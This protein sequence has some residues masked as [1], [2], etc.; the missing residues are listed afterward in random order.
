LVAAVAAQ[1]TRSP[2]RSARS[3]AAV[4]VSSPALGGVVHDLRRTVIRGQLG[5]P[6]VRVRLALSSS[7]LR[8]RLQ[9]QPPHL[10]RPAPPASRSARCSR[11]PCRASRTTSSVPN[12]SGVPVVPEQLE[13]VHVRLQFHQRFGQC[14]K[15]P[16]PQLGASRSRAGHELRAGRRPHPT[17][18]P[19]SP[20]AATCPYAAR[21]D[22]MHVVVLA[23]PLDRIRRPR[24]IPAHSSWWK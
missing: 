17:T 9:I 24:G 1:M 10:R 12:V 15:S 23:E 21:A 20:S 4:P 18:T 13:P 6:R 22:H 8:R 11:S 7:V 5:A 3:F 19:R 14:R 2:N 16:L